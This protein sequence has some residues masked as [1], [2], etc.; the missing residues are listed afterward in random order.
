MRRLE[1][2]HAKGAE[3]VEEAYRKCRQYAKV[4]Q[5]R[6][7]EDWGYAFPPPAP[8]AAATLPEPAQERWEAPHVA[9]VQAQQ[10]DPS[11]EQAIGV[12]AAEL[13]EQPKDRKGGAPEQRARARLPM[14]PKPPLVSPTKPPPSTRGSGDTR[15]GPDHRAQVIKR[16]WT[17]WQRASFRLRT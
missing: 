14:P 1:R 4:T 16:C 6:E 13:N 2:L 12:E 8:V 15:K 7:R 17:S 11:A 9:P 5:G 10:A 3:K